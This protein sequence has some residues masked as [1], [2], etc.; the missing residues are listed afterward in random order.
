MIKIYIILGYNGDEM[1][2]YTLFS[3][4]GYEEKLLKEM[5]LLWSFDEAMRLIMPRY[6]A[7]F[8]KGGKIFTEQR[9]LMPGYVFIESMLSGMDFYVL[10]RPLIL[11]SEYALKL[12]RYGNSSLDTNFEMK[13]DESDVFQQLFGD[14]GCVD[15][16]KGFI[17]G[18]LIIVTEG[19]LVGFEGMIKKINRHKMIAYLEIK[20]FGQLTR[21][22]VGLEIISKK[23]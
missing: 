6:D 3:K 19:P 4:T 23:T 21:T 16:S 12:L 13:S 20:I 17:E 22:E 18:D 14:K 2:F 9:R 1:G 8:R 5:E 11:W 7:K 15:M 10:S